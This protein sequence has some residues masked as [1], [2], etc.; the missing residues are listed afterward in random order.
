MRVRP[1]VRSGA[2]LAAVSSVL[3]GASSAGAASFT[4][5]RTDDPVPGACAVGD[6]SLREA[7]NAANAAP[8]STITVPAGTYTLTIPGG[9]DAATNPNIGDLDMLAAMTINGA[10]VGST[11]VQSGA[12]PFSGIHR[13]FDNHSTNAVVIS[14]MTIRNGYVDP[15]VDS[16]FAGCV[17]NTGVLTLSSVNVTGC[18]TRVGAGGVG[19][20]HNLTVVNSNITGNKVSS[21]TG[22]FVSGGG[23]S[24]GPGAILGASSTVTIINSSIT[25]N[26]AESAGNLINT[27][28][29]GGFVN[30]AI[31]NISFSVIDGNQA[32][33]VGGGISTGNMTIQ[34]STFSNNKARY[35][36]GGL[37][38]DGTMSIDGS[39]F[40]ANV[41]GFGCAT[42]AECNNALAGGILNTANGIMTVNNSTISGN[43]CVASSGGILNAQGSLTITSSTITLNTCNFAGGLGVSDTTSIKNTIIANNTAPLG[44]PDCA[45]TAAHLTSQGH[46]LIRSLSGCLMAGDTASNIT[47]VDPKLSAFQNNGGSTFTHALHFDS[48]AIDAGLACPATDQVGTARPQG[49]Q[50][51][52]GALEFVDLIFQDGFQTGDFSRWTANATSGGDLTVNGSSGLNST[53]LGLEAV[54]NDVNPIYVEDDTPTNEN[55][56]RARF[57]FDPRNFDPGEAQAHLRTRILI[58]FEENPTRRLATIVLRRQAGVYAIMGRCRLDDDTLADTP[59]FTITDAPHAIELDWR[60]STTPS[61]ND[62]RFELFIDGL[63]KSVLSTLDNNLSTV[64][65]ARMG[66]LSLKSGSGG[67][68]VFDEFVSR[69]KTLIGP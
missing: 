7:V 10:G 48:P 53:S 41:S 39:T 59:F 8:G 30:T 27:A 67:T 38:N 68:M 26:I 50:C 46:N 4:V 1:P 54:V 45:A 21:L 13:I 20:F 56:Y 63:S 44:G 58:A 19:S 62:G 23:I 66:G 31:M 65:F 3:L 14:N 69:R 64:D 29:G 12:T 55:R 42:P 25:N 16:S 52:I 33:Q 2:I 34:N 32:L 57:Y 51:D 22:A 5:S 47:G 35:D 36:T 60:Q 6:C 15:T 18:L 43:S 40:A 9:D 11:F 61:A 37:D 24:G 28:Q 49:P 17:R